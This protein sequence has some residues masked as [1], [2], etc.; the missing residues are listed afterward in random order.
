MEELRIRFPY[1]YIKAAYE[2]SDLITVPNDL[3]MTVRNTWE[4]VCLNA[5]ESNYHLA[6]WK[7]EG[8]RLAFEIP[9]DLTDGAG[10]FPYIK[11]AMFLYLSRVTG[12]TFDNAGSSISCCPSGKYLRFLSEKQKLWTIGSV[13]R[14]SCFE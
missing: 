3:P 5:K 4:P 7:Y 8:H 12:K 9:H 13:K 1:F 2:G 11:S 10:V 14:G 6:A